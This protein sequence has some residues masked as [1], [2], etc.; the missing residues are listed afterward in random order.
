[1]Y[2]LINMNMFLFFPFI[3]LFV[4][5]CVWESVC[6]V[7]EIKCRTLLMIG[8]CFSPK[9]Y[10]QPQVSW[11]HQS[12]SKMDVLAFQSGMSLTFLDHDSASKGVV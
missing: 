6:V 11:E 12:R 1:M 2:V 5:V 7:L 3:L 8:R 9:L 4:C 10:T